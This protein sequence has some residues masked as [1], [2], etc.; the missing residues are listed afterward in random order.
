LN[1]TIDVDMAVGSIDETIEVR[2]EPSLLETS[3][4]GQAVN[5]SGELLRS[6]PLL[7]R[8]EWFGAFV[9][10]PGVT[11]AEWVNNER[12]VSGHGADASANVVQIDGADVTPATGSSIQHV[13][14]SMEAVN[15]I[16][17]KTSGTDASAPLGLGGIVNIATA[18][19]TNQIR[20]AGSVS[21]QPGAWNASNTP[22]G[23]SA[24]VE[25]RQAEL[26]LGAPIVKDHVWAFGAY[27][28]T[29]VETG[30]SRT[31]AQL[32]ALRGL[33]P[34][35]A[36]FGS[37]NQAHF[38]FAKMTSRLSPAHELIALYQYDVNPTYVADATGPYTFAETTGGSGALLRLSSIW[39]HRLTT[40]AGASFNDKR[41]DNLR[42]EIEAPF[43]PVYQ[44]TFASAGLPVGNGFVANLGS[45][46]TAQQLQ[47]NSK[48]TLS[49][50]ATAAADGPFG[51]H[52][53]QSGVY[54]QPRTR[55]GR[56]VSY[57]NGGFIQEDFVLRRAGDYAAGALPFHR[58]VLDAT[59][60]VAAR[61][62]GQDY[63][64]YVQDAWRPGSRLTITA[65]L[66]IDRVTWSDALFDVEGVRST[67]IGPRLGVNVAMTADARNVARA[68]WVRVHDRP[69]QVATSVGSAT[70]GQRDLYDNNLDGTFETVLVTPPTFAVTGGRAFDPD[71]HVPFVDEWGTGYSRQFDGRLTVGVDVVRRNYRDR[72]TLVDVNSR[73]EGGRFV[74]Y[75]NEAFNATYLVTN[76]HWN[77]PVYTSAELSVTKRTAR[78]Q[79]IAS[80][81]RQWRHLDGTWQPND[82]A[83]FIQ[84]SAFGN[85]RGLG[86][87]N[88]SL[89]TPTDANSLSGTHMT[90]RSTASAQWQD[91]VVRSAVTYLAPLELLVGGSYTFQSGAWSGPIVSRLAAPDPAFGPS[92]ITLSNGRVVSNPLATTIR[93]AYANRGEGQLETPPFH[94]LN[95]RVGRRFTIAAVKLDAALDVFNLTNNGADLSFQSGANQQYNPLFGLTTFRQLPRSA[96]AFLRASF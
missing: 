52:E 96:Q 40:T 87:L 72:P 12:L 15:D 75:R 22:Q 63:A 11:S 26:S 70:L 86:G 38:G 35:Y 24:T 14:L 55:I 53:L 44:S 31:A 13:G 6:I 48:L 51:P 50:D 90:Q 10:A 4:A 29:D 91:H 20:A 61:A 79:G 84:P 47:P 68:H 67:E 64:I 46:T 60:I 73:Y 7:E 45:A 8:H 2:V 71:L 81:I 94:A 3:R 93:F 59:D 33:I 36:P 39:S 85:D 77:T 28:Y 57:L 95:L 25:Q 83:S 69:T 49:F 34:N 56:T 43:Q 30:V 92:T 89:S 66:R 19:G 58:I 54:I 88:G 82:P 9:V 21:I 18:S 17:I 16:Q 80:Y 74:G 78:V 32:E 42:P 62:E 76:N 37:S 41:R 27:R 5:V 1:V 23:T 65:G